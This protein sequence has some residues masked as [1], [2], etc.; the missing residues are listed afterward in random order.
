MIKLENVTKRIK[1]KTILKNVTFSINEYGI[2]GFIGDNGAG[3]TVIFKTIMGLYIPT[4]GDVYLNNKIISKTLEIPNNISCM[5]E[6]PE[7]FRDLTGI[8]NI[9]LLNKIGGYNI[10]YNKII[11]LFEYFDLDKNKKV[12]EYSRGMIQKLAIIQSIFEDKKI[13]ILDEPFEYIDKTCR[14]KL[15]KYLEKER[16]NKVILVSSHNEAD[17][18]DI[19][20]KIFFIEKGE[21]LYEKDFKR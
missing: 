8:E 20:K 15:K 3:K 2:Y 7:F 18:I 16:N 13:I 12:K 6:K 17:F 19:S 1:G 9:K 21:I 11:N 10:E 14:E 5:I 4:S